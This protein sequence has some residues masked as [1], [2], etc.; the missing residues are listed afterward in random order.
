ML[1]L[2]LAGSAQAHNLVA[3]VTEPADGMSQAHLVERW[4]QWA[5]R[6][7]P[8][9]RP[10]QDPTGMLCDLNQS[11]RIWFLAGTDGTADVVRHCTVPSGTWLFFPV[12]AMLASP[13]PGVAMTCAQA[14]A[15]AASNNT[16]LVQA[17]VRIDGHVV[18]DIARHR[19]GTPHCFDAYP[20]ASYLRNPKAYFPAAS[21]GYWLL[22][23]PLA[24]GAHRVEVHA[25]YDNPGSTLGDLE[26][27]F[28][29]ELQVQDEDGGPPTAENSQ[30]YI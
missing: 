20:D 8:G 24:T 25:R 22:L 6:V 3:P 7:P 16:H 30:D 1:L 15:K 28:I 10:Y 27:V 2:A 26:Q 5:D 14:V 29:Y 11:G 19:I 12:I 9:V 4:W 23:R 21:D 13:T 18:P 17:D